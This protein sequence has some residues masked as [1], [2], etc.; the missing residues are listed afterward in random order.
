M[1]IWLRR[2]GLE[3]CGDDVPQGIGI[4]DDIVPRDA[5]SR[6]VALDEGYLAL[7]RS[8]R[9]VLADAHGK[10]NAVRE[11]A[12]RDACDMHAEAQQAF[13]AARE[14][15]FEAGRHEALAQWY[16][17]TSKM[18]ASRREVQMAVH[19]RVADLVVA[20]V[21]RIVADQPPAVLFGQ[22]RQAVERIIDDNSTLRI[23]V[24]PEEYDAAANAFN[25]AAVAW[26]ARGRSVSVDV[27]ADR[28]LMPGSCICDSDLGSLDASLSVQLE[29]VRAA[30]TRAVDQHPPHDDDGG[31][32]E[33]W[34]VGTWGHMPSPST[35]CPAPPLSKEQM[36][37]AFA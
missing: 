2:A 21:E 16:E 7:E 25:D 1:V 13:D 20:A 4:D 14:R 3:G 11:A 9:V 32:D 36:Q 6:V 10:A 18:L 19:Q 28:S 15:G 17:H 5:V 35:L 8:Y 23:R 33:P 24:H 31:T 12:A 34:Q 37:G 30:V 27:T 22:A 26:R 29:A